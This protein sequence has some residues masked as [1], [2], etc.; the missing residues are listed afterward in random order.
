MEPQEW[1]NLLREKRMRGE[2][3]LRA[4]YEEHQY[5]MCGCREDYRGEWEGAPRVDEEGVVK[6][7]QQWRSLRNRGVKCPLNEAARRF[8]VN[9]TPFVHAT[10]QNSWLTPTAFWTSV[11]RQ[12][13]QRGLSCRAPHLNLLKCYP[14]SKA[15]SCETPGW[16]SACPTFPRRASEARAVLLSA[17]FLQHLVGCLPLSKFFF[18]LMNDIKKEKYWLFKS[19]LLIITNLA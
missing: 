3:G 5:L 2:K 11:K 8:L 16:A 7:D 19:W 18:K 17:V 6:R 14:L 10:Y 13:P 12:F 15:L 9:P 4:N 1:V